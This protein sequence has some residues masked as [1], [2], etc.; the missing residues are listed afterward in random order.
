MTTKY[1]PE[2]YAALAREVKRMRE[3]LLESGYT[4]GRRPGELVGRSDNGREI[5]VR[6]GYTH[7]SYRITAFGRKNG[8]RQGQVYVDLNVG[9]DSSRVTEL[10]RAITRW[11]G[12]TWPP[13][14][15]FR[16]SSTGQ[17]EGM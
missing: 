15:E 12:Q 11:D 4:H 14:P 13:H 2:D 1:G 17:G 9:V 8:S 6:T 7:G 5:C 10:T 16:V 3:Q